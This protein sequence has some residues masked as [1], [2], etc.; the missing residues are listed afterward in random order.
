M[1]FLICFFC[2]FF[3]ILKILSYTLGPL[4]S[5]RDCRQCFVV[6]LWLSHTSNLLPPLL[7]LKFTVVIII[8]SMCTYEYMHATA[9]IWKSEKSLKSF[10]FLSCDLSTNAMSLD[11]PASIFTLES[12]CQLLVFF[13]S[14]IFLINF[15]EANKYVQNSICPLFLHR[16]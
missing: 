12:C 8:V 10:C 9:C 5:H 11:L 3:F 16:Q 14:L 2:F 4:L 1:R 15:L 7:S 6:Y 13:F